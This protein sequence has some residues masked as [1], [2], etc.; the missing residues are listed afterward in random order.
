[1]LKYKYKKRILYIWIPAHRGITE[2][3][4]A[5]QLAKE[6]A[7]EEP[8][9]IIEV[10]V[11][12]ARKLFKKEAWLN[13]QNRIKAEAN[14]KEIFYF[15]NFYKE[16]R[17]KPWFYKFNKERYFITFINRIRSNHYNLN[18]SLARKSYIEEARCECGYEREVPIDHVIWQC[19]RYDDE[20]EA[21]GVELE[22]RNL[23]GS[24]S[25]FDLIKHN[26]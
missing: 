10:P 14:Y 21:L 23:R 4:I 25:I 20:R 17:K 24:E 2:N 11:R 8:S 16:N 19:H 12:D 6:A 7:H 13:T 26:Q 22:R 1:M 3:E 15:E 18:E 5:D 9:Q